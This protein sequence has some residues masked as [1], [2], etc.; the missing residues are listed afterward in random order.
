MGRAL[1]VSKLES[2][3]TSV[4]GLAQNLNKEADTIQNTVDEMLNKNQPVEIDN[5]LVNKLSQKETE[6]IAQF[7]KINELETKLEV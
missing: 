5:A 6:I 1:A 7:P 3:K 4:S 2:I